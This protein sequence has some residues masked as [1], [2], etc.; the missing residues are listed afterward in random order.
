MTTSQNLVEK[1]KNILRNVFTCWY[2][3]DELIYDE[4]EMKTFSSEINH[5]SQLSF[6]CS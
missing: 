4:L 2:Q 6:T 5:N 1:F 3:V